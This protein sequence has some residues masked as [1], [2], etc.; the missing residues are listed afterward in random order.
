MRQGRGWCLGISVVAKHALVGN[1]T[2]G[3]RMMR[4]EPR[5][6]RP[7]SGPLRVPTQG[8]FDQRSPLGAMQVRPR[9]IAGTH[10]VVDLH[11]FDVGVCSV[12][13]G[14]PASLV[15]GSVMNSHRIMRS[16]QGM[17]VL[18][19]FFVVFD[20]VVRRGTKQG[21]AH[22]GA[23]IAF[24]DGTMAICAGR[25]V[26]IFVYRRGLRGRR[27]CENGGARQEERTK[28]EP[29]PHPQLPELPNIQQPLAF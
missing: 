14:L 29:D 13:A 21:L 25:R 1:E 17:R 10:H 9:M 27:Y 6:H 18:V 7:V 3:L 15:E 22:A 16:G 8:Q 28:N 23:A 2:P 26:D 4:I 24:I 19:L 20:G 12:E 11:V 5:T